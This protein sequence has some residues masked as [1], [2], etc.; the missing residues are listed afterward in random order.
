M[1]MGSSLSSTTGGGGGGGRQHEGSGGTGG[2]EGRESGGGVGAGGG[3]P[4]GDPVAG[5]LKDRDPRNWSEVSWKSI[6]LARK[7]KEHRE[8]NAKEEKE[9]L[10]LLEPGQSQKKDAGERK[11]ADSAGGGGAEVKE[12][13]RRPLQETES[14][15]M[16]QHARK[17]EDDFIAGGAQNF[18]KPVRVCGSCF[19]VSKPFAFWEFAGVTSM[20]SVSQVKLLCV[21]SYAV[22]LVEDSPRQP[23]RSTRKT[24]LDHLVFS[25]EWDTW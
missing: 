9:A 16:R 3:G 8:R 19:R 5:G 14:S 15:T 18:Y 4:K 23:T 1:E 13:R 21:P 24:P 6:S 22:Y 25:G 17:R 2:G 7:E 10:C 20:P 11:T 12:R